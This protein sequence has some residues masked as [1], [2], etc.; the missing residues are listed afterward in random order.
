MGIIFANEKVIDRMRSLEAFESHLLFQMPINSH[1]DA[2]VSDHT[3]LSLFVSDVVY[4]APN[5]FKSF[6][7]RLDEMRQTSIFHE[8]FTDNLEDRIICGVK[9]LKQEYPHNIAY[10]AVKLKNH[11]FHKLEY[12]ESEILESIIC[13]RIE[14]NQGYTRCSTM[15]LTEGAVITEDVGLAQ[16]YRNYGYEVLVVEKGHVVL[17]GFNY[18]FFGGTGGVIED[19][20]VLNGALKY[21][22]DEVAIRA[23]V[24]GF[25]LRI[26]ELYDGPLVDCGSIL[27]LSTK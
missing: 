20:L 13:D 25:G 11:F 4:V 14:V 5:I 9:L 17:P 21:H 23:F 18:G 15:V 10:N 19:V 3:D 6:V 8:H 1:V 2:R 27:Y 24:H 26:E 7:A 12:T 22:P 16:N